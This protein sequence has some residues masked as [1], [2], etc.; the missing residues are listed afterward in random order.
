MRMA[1]PKKTV[2]PA[3]KRAKAT[4]MT[5]YMNGKQKRV[6]RP[7]LL[8]SLDSEEFILNNANPIWL[9]Q[10]GLWEHMPDFS[11]GAPDAIGADAD[12]IVD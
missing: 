4:F 1:Q 10:N 6:L 3:R 8:D 7:V 12:D 11:P 5:I 9:H 2:P